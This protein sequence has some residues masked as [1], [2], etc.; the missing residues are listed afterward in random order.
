[1]SKL[2]L[3]LSKELDNGKVRVWNL[4]LD[5]NKVT[6]EYG[7]SE[8]EL[9]VSEKVFDAGKAGRNASEEALKDAYKKATSKIDDYDI[10]DGSYD[11]IETAYEDMLSAVGSRKEAEKEKAKVEKAE[12]KAKEKAEAK[13]EVDASE[14]EDVT[15]FDADSD[16][17]NDEVIDDKEVGVETYE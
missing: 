17:D 15:N 8:S 7:L 1:M 6:V 12:A 2:Y 9:K 3:K 11:D 16:D 5:E 13:A 10:E 4:N 14:D